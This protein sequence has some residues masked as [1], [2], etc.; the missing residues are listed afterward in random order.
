MADYQHFNGQQKPWIVG[1]PELP[2]PSQQ[3]STDSPQH[4]WFYVLY[5][6][7]DELQM[8]LDFVNWGKENGDEAWT[9]P[10]GYHLKPEAQAGVKTNLLG[11]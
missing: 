10:V 1:P 3:H 2:V 7:N 5:Q 8:G 4:L 9:P 6:L 11:N